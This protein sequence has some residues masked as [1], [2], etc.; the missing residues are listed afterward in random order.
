MVKKTAILNRRSINRSTKQSGGKSKSKS[1]S[2]GKSKV[3]RTSKS[4][5]NGRRTSKSNGKGNRKGN[6]KV[7]R[8]RNKRTLGKGLKNR[9]QF[10]GANAKDEAEARELI[11]VGL[12]YLDDE[13]LDETSV[14]DCVGGGAVPAR[15]PAGSEY[16]DNLI[17][18]YQ[19]IEGGSR[20]DGGDIENLRQNS[21]D[22]ESL[23]L[24][25]RQ[26]LSRIVSF[27][28][29]VTLVGDGGGTEQL[30]N[31]QKNLS[32][33]YLNNKIYVLGLYELHMREDIPFRT[34]IKNFYDACKDFIGGV[35]KD[36]AP[37]KEHILN[38]FGELIK[39][40]GTADGV[41]D[42]IVRILC[43][44]IIADVNRYI[45][46]DGKGFETLSTYLTNDKRVWPFP[47][48]KVAAVKFG[49]RNDKVAHV[50]QKG[51]T[52]HTCELP[53]IVKG[54]KLKKCGL[55]FATQAKV[56][57]HELVGHTPEEEWK[58]CEVMIPA[59]GGSQVACGWLC[60][61]KITM[62]KHMKSH[63]P[64]EWENWHLDKEMKQMLTEQH[65]QFWTRE[66]KQKATGNARNK[67]E[68]LVRSSL[69]CQN[70]TKEATEMAEEAVEKLKV[71]EM[72]LKKNAVDALAIRFFSN[73]RGKYSTIK[74]ALVGAAAH[75]SN[76]ESK[77]G[78]GI[79]K[80]QNKTKK[81]LGQKIY[82]LGNFSFRHKTTF[83]RDG[84]GKK[85]CLHRDNGTQCT[86][87]V[88]PLDT[89]CSKGHNL[90]P[91]S[92]GNGVYT[93]NDNDPWTKDKPSDYKKYEKKN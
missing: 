12:V 62:A 88:G 68:S 49:D 69:W 45:N 29:Y 31:R 55:T 4:N 52:I 57:Y 20:A 47:V 40:Y 72:A 46:A 87:W 71:N 25:E 77:G 90:L 92:D 84:T 26:E 83:D 18:S 16:I 34:N 33:T 54:E 22:I 8:T 70:Q 85:Q 91:E 32:P 61:G 14:V 43:E 21:A 65:R 89:E 30:T 74:K 37:A 76:Q 60:D 23:L 78:A 86:A 44:F 24:E 56:K 73:D 38:T 66:D 80:Q 63:E 1:K 41:P 82:K 2:N 50:I 11:G 15:P 17:E 10:G 59:D 48:K 51:E 53:A 67:G 42:D 79:L 39:K 13:D 81:T 75:I 64:D 27:H 3:Q 9:R 19:F 58:Q 6:S 93:D 28:P 35:Y 7:R 36:K 5:S